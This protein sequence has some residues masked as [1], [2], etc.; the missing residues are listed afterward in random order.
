MFVIRQLSY[1]CMTYWLDWCPAVRQHS[2]LHLRLTRITPDLPWVFCFQRG[3]LSLWLLIVIHQ[4]L[5]YSWVCYLT[6]CGCTVQ[7]AAAS[8]LIV[9]TSVVGIAFLCFVCAFLVSATFTR[10][11][12]CYLLTSL[13]SCNAHNSLMSII[14]PD[15]G[16]LFLDVVYFLAP[17]LKHL[18]F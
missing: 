3:R 4:A 5:R 6:F 13:S 10:K 14:I 18:L 12:H 11:R 9:S 2:S 16:L 8:F 1:H 17:F 7:A 15:A